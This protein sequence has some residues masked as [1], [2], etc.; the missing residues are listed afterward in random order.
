MLRIFFDSPKRRKIPSYQSI[1]FVALVLPSAGWRSNAKFRIKAEE[2]TPRSSEDFFCFD[3]DLTLTAPDLDAFPLSPLLPLLFLGGLVPSL[4]FDFCF[5]PDEAS[6]ALAFGLSAFAL[7]FG[8]AA[9]ASAHADQ[10]QT[11]LE[12]EGNEST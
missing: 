7:S 1:P 12:L 4:A 5:P 2:L 6:L 11:P 9:A 10:V 3:F 8:F